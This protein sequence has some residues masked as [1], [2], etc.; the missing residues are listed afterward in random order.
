MSPAVDT[1]LQ[2]ATQARLPQ[3]RGERP[4]RFEPL[5]SPLDI[6]LPRATLVKTV[7]RP[8]GRGV[9]RHAEEGRGSRGQ[10]AG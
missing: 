4:S 3:T 7:S 10:D 8:G 5:M 1:A 6:D 9:V 2:A